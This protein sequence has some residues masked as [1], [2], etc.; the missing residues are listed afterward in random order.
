MPASSRPSV[1]QMTV[2]VAC[3]WR[4]T[5]GLNAP[6]PLETASTPVMAVQPLA[7]ARSRSQAV[8]AWPAWPRCGGATTA[9][10]CPLLA[11]T[12]QRPTAIRPRKLA[13]KT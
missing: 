12:R 6:T 13:M 11:T 9:W 7:K 2:S 1:R 8:T 5:G 3:A 10:G 4:V